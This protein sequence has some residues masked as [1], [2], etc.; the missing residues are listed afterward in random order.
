[1]GGIATGSDR[2]LW[3]ASPTASW[4]VDESGRIQ[5]RDGSYDVGNGVQYPGNVVVASGRHIVYGYHGEAWR[6]GQ[7]NQW[8]HFHDSGLFIGQ[9]GRPGIAGDTSVAPAE[10]AGNTFSPQLVT[11]NGEFYLWHNDE[12][13]HAG[14]HRWRIDGANQV[15]LLE[16]TIEP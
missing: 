6:G 8:L 1:L 15:R 2:W 7:A 11:V 4:R 3:R 5:P 14:V 12:S 13:G 10:A 16:A 9:F